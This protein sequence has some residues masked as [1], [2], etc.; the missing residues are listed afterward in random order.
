[1]TQQPYVTDTTLPVA[2]EITMTSNGWQARLIA[3][4][5]ELRRAGKRAILFIDGM[6]ILVYAAEP[7]GIISL[8]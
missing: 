3:K 8:E 5:D 6:K 1:M 2:A 4:V 7:K